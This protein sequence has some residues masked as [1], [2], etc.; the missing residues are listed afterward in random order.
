VATNFRTVDLLLRLEWAAVL[1]AAVAGY[2]FLDGSWQLFV[3][4]ILAPD[5]AMLGYLAGPVAGAIV[6]NAFHV[7]V[8]PVILFFAGLYA[9]G[10][11]LMQVAAIW[12]AHIA[13]DRA[14]LRPQ[15][16]ER[17]HRHPSRQDRQGPIA[18]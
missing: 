1:A 17:L 9:G 3:L 12:I 8:W 5:L 2:L 15:A 6:Y 4:L 14:R 11:I 10:A 7:L 13:M 18:S 16:A